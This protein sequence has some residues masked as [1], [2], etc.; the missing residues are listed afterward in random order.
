MGLFSPRRRRR[1]RERLGHE[2][3]GAVWRGPPI[4]VTC[5]CEERR[6]LAYGERWTCETCGRSWDTAQ[7]PAEEYERIRRLQLRFRV[8]PVCIGLTVL[9]LAAFFTLTGNI[10]SVFFLL[11]VAMMSWFMLIRPV[12][13]RRYR[14]AISHLPTWNLRVE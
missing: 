7:I 13:R 3:P 14:E 6:D 8:L 11:P 10:F 1:Q 9:G 2:K 12:H 5:E 4:T